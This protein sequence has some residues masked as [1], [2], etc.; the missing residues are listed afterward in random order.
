MKFIT[1]PAMAASLL[2]SSVPANEISAATPPQ[3][4]GA[5][6]LALAGAALIAVGFARRNKPATQGDVLPVLADASP[7]P[8]FFRE[9]D[10][11][12]N[13]FSPNASG[14][15]EVI[16]FTR[17]RRPSGA[18]ARADGLPPVLGVHLERRL[19]ERAERVC[20]RYRHREEEDH[21]NENL[22]V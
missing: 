17:A 1:L 7:Q 9:N 2:F 12:G 15:A 4:G 5:L 21:A 20:G 16:E 10:M 8:S 11:T 19:V 18:Q 22:E 13:S 6:A 3:I 14:G